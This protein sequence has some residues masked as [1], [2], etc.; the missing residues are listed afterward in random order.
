MIQDQCEEFLGVL[1]EMSLCN[2]VILFYVKCYVFVPGKLKHLVF[3]DAL[4]I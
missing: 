1:T 3:Y 4:S 2:F